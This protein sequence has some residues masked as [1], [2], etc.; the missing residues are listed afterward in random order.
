MRVLAIDP[1]LHTGFAHS[2]GRHGVWNFTGHRHAG[3]PPWALVNE[4][5]ML[6]DELGIELVITEGGF[7][8]NFKGKAGLEAMRAAVQ[9]AAFRLGSVK[10]RM[11]SPSTLK[12]YATGHGHADKSQ[13]I[14]ACIDRLGIVPLSDDHADALFLL[15]MARRNQPAEKIVT[16]KKPRAKKSAVPKDPY[17]PVVTGKCAKPDDSQLPF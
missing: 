1:G 2:A 15:H 7:T 11:V 13:V 14:R 5:V 16:P 6:G 4:I 3:G 10:V 8:G 17:R 9:M 12:L